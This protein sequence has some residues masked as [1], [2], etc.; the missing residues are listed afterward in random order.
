MGDFFFLSHLVFF[1]FRIY[2]ECFFEEAGSGSL[3]HICCRLPGQIFVK[4]HI[5]VWSIIDEVGPPSDYWHGQLHKGKTVCKHVR[6][7]MLEG[8]W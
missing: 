7:C 6:W 1:I 5:L 2:F 4:A 8:R 3:S